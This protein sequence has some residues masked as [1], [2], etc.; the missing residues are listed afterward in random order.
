MTAAGD[1]RRSGGTYMR[2]H[3]IAPSRATDAMAA[4]SRR[5]PSGNGNVDN[6]PSPMIKSNDRGSSRAAIQSSHTSRSTEAVEPG[7]TN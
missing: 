3:Q 1:S 6:T 5:Y 2:R 7:Q 4:A